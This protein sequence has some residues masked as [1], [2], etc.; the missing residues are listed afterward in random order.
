MMSWWWLALIMSEKWAYLVWMK[1]TCPDW[2][3]M[4]VASWP[5]KKRK[6][7]HLLLRQL[8]M[9]CWK[10]IF[11]QGKLRWL[12]MW[13]LLQQHVHSDSQVA[14]THIASDPEFCWKLTED[15]LVSVM[16]GPCCCCF[17][18]RG[19]EGQ[20]TLA[21]RTHDSEYINSIGFFWPLSWPGKGIK[22]SA[23]KEVI[24]VC[25]CCNPLFWNELFLRMLRSLDLVTCKI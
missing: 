12:L 14:F 24:G 25:T 23:C 9:C 19:N 1:E 17:W 4:K 22:S 6:W 10:I 2:A 5:L 20:L 21:C 11:T 8:H 16:D 15:A 7:W 3:E 18:T 13:G